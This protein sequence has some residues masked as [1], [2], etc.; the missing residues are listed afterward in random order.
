M[1]VSVRADE[2]GTVTK[3][4]AWK[5]GS[6]SASKACAVGVTDGPR[7][8]CWSVQ[9]LLWVRCFLT[10]GSPLTFTTASSLA[11]VKPSDT[12]SQ[13]VLTSW[14]ERGKVSNAGQVRIGDQGLLA[15]RSHSTV[16]ER[17][18]VWIARVGAVE[19]RCV[20]RSMLT[21]APALPQVVF[22]R[23]H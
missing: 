6:P 4:H 13:L 9:H 14:G 11:E 16:G 19:R 8:T 3:D 22:G 7:V 1:S 21:S 20:P 5:P 17:I 10:S 12:L 23:E 2:T 15:R 18:A